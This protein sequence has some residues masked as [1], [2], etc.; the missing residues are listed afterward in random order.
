MNIVYPSFPRSSLIFFNNV[1]YFFI[2]FVRFISRYVIFSECGITT[3][4]D[5]QIN[6]GSI[7]FWNVK[8]VLYLNLSV[9]THVYN[10]THLTILNIFHLF[11]LCLIYH[12]KPVWKEK[13]SKDT[14][15]N[16]EKITNNKN[17]NCNKVWWFL[18][19]QHKVFLFLMILPDTFIYY[20]I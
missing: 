10:C 18:T 3:R 4:N 13:Y 7:L 11:S 6:G 19:D 12:K 2:P 5:R 17:V 9:Y 14:V 15:D 16:L 8:N 1:L 20:Y